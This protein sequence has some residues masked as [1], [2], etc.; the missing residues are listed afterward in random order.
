[1]S[2][3]NRLGTLL[4]S[5]VRTA[6]VSSGWQGNP[7]YRG[8]VVFL[9]TTAVPGGGTETLT[10]KVESRNPV[11]GTVITLTAFGAT[12][13]DFSGSKAYMVYPGTVETGAVSDLEVQGVPLPSEWR[14]TVTPSSTGSWTYSVGYSLVQ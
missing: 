1:M 4:A 6:A 12:A 9:E 3:E 13:A 2:L 8:A 10:V 5:A 14:V 7:G 11:T